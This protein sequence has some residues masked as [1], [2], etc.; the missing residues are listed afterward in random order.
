MIDERRGALCASAAPDVVLMDLSM[1][2]LDG[3]DATRA[4]RARWPAVRVI[5][6]TSFSDRQ[7]ILAAL[8][9]GA[10][11]H[12]LNDAEPC[13]LFEGFGRPLGGG[14]TRQVP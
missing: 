11:G 6:L 5:V 1:L 13:A 9:G 8:R 3:I 12:L 4:I 7:R 14:R 2:V 10:V